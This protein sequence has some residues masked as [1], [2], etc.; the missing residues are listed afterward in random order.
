VA[1]TDPSPVD[2][3]YSAASAYYRGSVHF[4]LTGGGG[5]GGGGG[6]RG[7]AAPGQVLQ[8]GG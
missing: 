1:A 2:P 8:T 4:I 6:G 5:G 7:A 3:V